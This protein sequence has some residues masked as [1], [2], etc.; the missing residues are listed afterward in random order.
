MI[1]KTVEITISTDFVTLGQ[2]LKIAD[3]IGS[4]GEAKSFLASHEILVDGVSDNR[5]GRKL[6]DEMVVEI[7]QVGYRIVKK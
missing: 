2:L 7:D 3:L 6:R 4:G 5:R 1:K